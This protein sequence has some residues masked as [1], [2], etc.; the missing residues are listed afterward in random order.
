MIDLIP[1][2]DKFVIYQVQDIRE[3]PLEIL[4]SDFFSVTKTGEEISILT[5]SPASFF[6]IES[7]PGWRGFKVDGILDFSLVG[8]IHALATPMKENNISVFVISTFNTDYL[9]VKE[10]NFERAIELFQQTEKIR[11]K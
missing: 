9:F 1:L 8:I 2:P 6:G 4:E 7:E 11:I 10:D 5:N 3:I